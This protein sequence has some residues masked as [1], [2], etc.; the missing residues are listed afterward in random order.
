MICELLSLS[1]ANSSDEERFPATPPEPFLRIATPLTL[2]PV[3]SSTPHPLP[4]K[5]SSVLPYSWYT[6]HL[7]TEHLENIA[8]AAAN[9]WRRDRQSIKFEIPTDIP[10]QLVGSPYCGMNFEYFRRTSDDSS[11]EANAP[12]IRPPLLLVY[13]SE[14]GCS[15]VPSHPT[16]PNGGLDVA[17]F[18][19]EKV[20]VANLWEK[21]KILVD[22]A[23]NYKEELKVYAE[24]ASHVSFLAL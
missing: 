11:D 3:S 17:M 1:Y 16:D 5:D 23:A 21:F 12:S 6:A 4:L 18:V 20:Y 13:M 15:H 14:R 7:N 8:V 10:S 9:Q 19:L 2:P 24:I 22:D